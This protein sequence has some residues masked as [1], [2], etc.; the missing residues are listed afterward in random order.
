MAALKETRLCSENTNQSP[1]RERALQIATKRQ[2]GGKDWGG[3][4]RTIL[5]AG[6]KPAHLDDGECAG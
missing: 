4:N 1:V 3:D 2:H 5:G 6:I